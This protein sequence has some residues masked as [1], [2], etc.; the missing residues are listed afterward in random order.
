MCV[1]WVDGGR[2]HGAGAVLLH[3]GASMDAWNVCEL[4]HERSKQT[5]EVSWLPENHRPGKGFNSCLGSKWGMIALYSL[6]LFYKFH[7][8][9]KEKDFTQPKSKIW[10]KCFV[11][12]KCSLPNFDH[13]NKIVDDEC[14]SWAALVSRRLRVRRDFAI[15]KWSLEAWFFCLMG[16]SS[17]GRKNFWL[18]RLGH[19]VMIGLHGL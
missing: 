14:Q 19:K 16:T 17:T 5:R 15:N 1:W 9:S 3:L 11:G 8:F 7:I 4:T 18:P 2:G 10:D 12:V 6:Q 13:P